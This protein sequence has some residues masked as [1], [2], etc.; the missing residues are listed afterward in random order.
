LAAPIPAGAGDFWFDST[1]GAVF[2]GEDCVG[3]GA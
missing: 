1:E 2:T 3:N